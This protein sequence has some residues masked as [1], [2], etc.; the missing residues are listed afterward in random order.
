LVGQLTAY[1]DEKRLFT[2]RT[3]KAYYALEELNEEAE[4]LK[5]RLT[6]QHLRRLNERL[7]KKDVHETGAC[8][9]DRWN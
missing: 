7:A 3:I 5:L 4:K 9:T 1:F 6:L 8:P 2:E